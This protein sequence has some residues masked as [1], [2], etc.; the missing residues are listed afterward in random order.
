VTGDIPQSNLPAMQ[1]DELARAVFTYG[2]PPG[3]SEGTDYAKRRS[4][5]APLDRLAG[6]TP[7]PLYSSAGIRRTPL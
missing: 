1:P 4:N 2:T 5:D 3:L 7:T 6:R